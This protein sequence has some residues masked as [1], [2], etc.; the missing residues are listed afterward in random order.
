MPN[1]RTAQS[2]EVEAHEHGAL[3][4]WHPSRP[5]RDRGIGA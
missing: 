4:I 2:K 3:G 5:P 1:A